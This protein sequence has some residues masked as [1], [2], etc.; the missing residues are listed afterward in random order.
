MRLVPQKL[1]F[2][3]TRQPE[4]YFICSAGVEVQGVL[5][6]HPKLLLFS[7]SGDVL[8]LDRMRAQVG[9]DGSGRVGVQMYREGAYLK[10]AILKQGSGSS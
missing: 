3:A 2:P 7:P 10:G 6:R 4:E 8:A 1:L 9:K 5:E